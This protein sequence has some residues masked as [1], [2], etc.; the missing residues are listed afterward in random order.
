MKHGY[1]G[2]ILFVDLTNGTLKEEDMTEELARNFIGG[3]GIGARILYDR[4]KPGVDP[5][6]PDNILGFTTGPLTGTDAFLSGRYT[7]VCK[8]PVT[9][10]W[11]DANS[12]GFFGP[13]LKK[14][15]FDAVFVSGISEKPVYIFIKDG[16][17]EIRDAVNIWGKDCTEALEA[18]IRETG[19]SRLRAAMIGP[20]GEKKSLISCVI[21]EKHRAAGRGGSGAVMGSKNL[22]A[23]AVRGTG[24]IS[25]S[26]P[27]EVKKVNSGILDALKNGPG[28]ELAGIFGEFGTG[29]GTGHMALIG[30]TPVKNWG[31]VGIVDMGNESAEKLG[32]PAYD[33]KYKTKKYACNNCPL[34]CGAHYR[35]DDGKWPLGETDRPEYETLGAFGAMLLNSD[36]ESIMKCNDIC[37]RYGLDTISTGATISWAM[38]CYENGLV[39]KEDTDGIDLSWGN[40]DAIVGMTQAIADQTGFGKI[41]ALGSSGAA[42]KLGKGAEYLQTVRG[43]E[44]PMHDPKFLPGLSRVYNL[45]PTPARHV[46]GGYAMM[47]IPA[48]PEVKYRL[49]GKGEL[50][51]QATYAMEILNTSGMCQFGTLFMP[52]DANQRLMAAVTGWDFTQEEL[53]RTG[54]RI[55][56]MRYAFNLREGQRLDGNIIPA[57]SVGEPPQ[58]EGPL[59]G[60]TIDYKLLASQFCENAGWDK[61]SMMPTRDSLVETGGLEDVIKDIYS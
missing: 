15:G 16:K 10:G 5:L 9:G 53:S 49:E 1:A 20:A 38:E 45:D 59:K 12:G 26:D 18:L 14:A 25:M 28:S 35:V 54:K 11:N 27:G 50:D 44:L 13:E 22:K 6:G 42:K 52:P 39:T 23:V 4:M 33:S 8:S 36:I 58:K 32:T 51:A 19:E 48:S 56:N 37:N 40:A 17:A 60:I 43:I 61:E 7:V 46:K 29:S 57:R 30:D 21:N 3:Y 34:G 55:L 2:K 31:G 41:L 47:E 24:K